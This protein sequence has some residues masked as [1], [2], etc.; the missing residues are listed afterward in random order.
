M[1]TVIEKIYKRHKNKKGGKLAAYIPE[2]AKVDPK[3]FSIV[4]VDCCGNIHKVGDFKKEIA[5]ESVSKVFT[6]CMALTERGDKEVADKIGTQTSFMPFNS[7][8]AL[9]MSKSHTMN[10][11]VNAGAIA[12][13]S[14]VKGTKAASWKKI[15]GNMDAFAGRKLGFSESVYRSEMKT[16]QH[17]V[18]LSYMLKSLG[19]FY[20]DVEDSVDV[21]TKQCSVMVNAIDLATMA[22]VLANKGRHP[23]TGKQIIKASY[24]P[25]VLSAMMGSG[26][27][28]YSG[29]WMNVVGIPSKS[30]VGGGIIG[31]VPGHFGIAVVSPPLD[32]NGN[33]HKGVAVMKELSAA[34][35]LNM[36]K[37]KVSCARKC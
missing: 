34:L 6:L 28:N 15:K 5:I 12:T 21:Y 3:I 33:S 31:V 10:P 37:S 22:A 1:D 17:N 30:G 8:I 24:V 26:M 18:A 13:T 23:V 36:F 2:L 14:L 27:Y 9:K 29:K 11:F 20:G 25:F 4:I 32:E 7:I 19:R 35:D 16:N